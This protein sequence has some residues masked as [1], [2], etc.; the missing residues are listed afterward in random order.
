MCMFMCIIS[1]G[2]LVKA[3]GHLQ[4]D[5]RHLGKERLSTL[6]VEQSISASQLC[7]QLSELNQ[8]QTESNQP[9]AS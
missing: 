3:L 4:F 5:L 2:L 8:H 7:D 1:P 6:E 9:R